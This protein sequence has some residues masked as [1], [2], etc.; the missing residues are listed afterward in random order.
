MKSIFF[1]SAAV[2]AL[3]VAPAARAEGIRAEVH[4]GYDNVSVGGSSDDG[5]AYGV[6]L[7]YDAAIGNSMEIGVELNAD[8]SNVKD[9][10]S[11]V[12]VVGDR[13]CILAGRDLSAVARL[14]YKLGEQSTLYAIAGYTN[15]KVVARY[16]NGASTSRISD[17]GDGIRVGAGYQ[18]AFSG[19]AYGKVEYRYSNYEGGF[20]RHQVLTGIGI[21]F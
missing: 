1:V 12:V 18:F 20:S 13:S 3:L 21:G 8:D 7:G 17:N 11:N 10:V 2:A 19:K 5:I 6:A 9:C 14:G 16:T 15:A 4:G